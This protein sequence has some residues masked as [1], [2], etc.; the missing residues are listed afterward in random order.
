MIA[1]CST[2]QSITLDPGNAEHF[3]LPNLRRGYVGLFLNATQR[4]VPTQ[5]P[6][7]DG[8]PSSFWLGFLFVVRGIGVLLRRLCSQQGRF[9][10]FPRTL[11]LAEP[12]SLRGEALCRFGEWTLCRGAVAEGGRTFAPHLPKSMRNEDLCRLV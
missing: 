3:R 1:Q 4:L 11:H 8:R 5:H 7:I 10:D 9:R 6:R 12:Q 2:L